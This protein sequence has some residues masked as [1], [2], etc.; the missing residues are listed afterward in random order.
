MRGGFIYMGSGRGELT[1][2]R[3]AVALIQSF[4]LAWEPINSFQVSYPIIILSVELNLYSE[5]K[6]NM[7]KKHG[8]RWLVFFAQ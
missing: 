5:K 2:A 3:L 7:E 4:S 8:D 6:L 1:H